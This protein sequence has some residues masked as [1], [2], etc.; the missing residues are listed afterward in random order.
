M[1]APDVSEEDVAGMQKLRLSSAQWARVLEADAPAH[2]VAAPTPCAPTPCAYAVFLEGNAPRREWHWYERWLDTA[3]QLAQPAHA[4]THV[5]LLVPPS[6]AEDD[7]HFA[8]YLGRE[9]RWGRARSGNKQF[10]L[11]PHGN[12][13]SWRAVPVF[14]KDVAQRLRA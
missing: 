9:A 5:E 11:D 8:T 7:L 14:G 2:G 12:A 6:Q 3:V 1:D 4:M 13:N 10:Y